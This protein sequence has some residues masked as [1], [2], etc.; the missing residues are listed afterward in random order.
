MDGLPEGV[1]AWC[2]RAPLVAWVGWSVVARPNDLFVTHRFMR[3]G[4]VEHSVQRIPAAARTATTEVDRQCQKAT[5][6]T[7]GNPDS[8]HRFGTTPG[9]RWRDRPVASP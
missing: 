9:T 3:H 2:V 1:E 8:P 6:A 4:E 7:P 5:V